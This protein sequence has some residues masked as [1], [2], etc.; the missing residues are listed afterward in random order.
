VSTKRLPG[1]AELTAD[2]VRRWTPPERNG[3]PLIAAHRPLMAAGEAAWLDPL[4]REELDL[5]TRDIAVRTGA[6]TAVLAVFNPAER[7]VELL[8][9]SDAGA[10][11]D[12]LAARLPPAG[13]VG[14][15][16]ESGRAVFEPID[17]EHDASLGIVSSGARLRYAAGAAVRPP[18]GPPG[19]LCVGFATVPA[20][21][22]AI[23][24][25]LVERYAGLA[26]LC[27]HDAGM[28]ERWLA[29]PQLD[30]LTGCLSYAAI[31]AELDREIGR[32]ERHGLSLSCCFIDLDRFKSVND[33]HGHLQGNR[34]LADVAKVLR[35]ALRICDTLGRYGGDEF[36]AI[37]PD[38]GQSAACVLANRLRSTISTTT[39]DGAN[40]PL[41]ASVGVAQWRPHQTAEELL[42][43]ADKALLNAKAAGGG[44]VVRARDMVAGAPRDVAVS[45]R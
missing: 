4:A 11:R 38:T 35:G 23:V 40:E 24:L 44:T 2:D 28:L 20:E 37:L 29:A 27:L 39:P 3:R 22:P 42:A 31:R 15:I 17:S 1:E 7:L 32:S 9:A 5:I 10:G 41:D 14:R 16:L 21:D 43:A 34:V 18:G 36:V 33:R 45:E 13:F 30:E 26:S 19:A 6:E 25:W 12:H 8:C